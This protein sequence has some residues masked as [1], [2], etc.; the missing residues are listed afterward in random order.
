MTNLLSEVHPITR[1]LIWIT[2]DGPSVQS[3]VYKDV[4]Y[5][6]NGLLTA[7]LNVKKLEGSQVLLSEN[8][9]KSFYVFITSAPSKTDMSNFENLVAPSMGL[10][11]EIIVIDEN[12]QF[13]ELT[14]GLT[15]PIKSWLR[16]VSLN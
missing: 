13:G 14:K 5:L 8:F 4:D 3:Q 12:G 15:G 2:K 10:E 6:L 16:P 11:N 9:G 7:T 1:G